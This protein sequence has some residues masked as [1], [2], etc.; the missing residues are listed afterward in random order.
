MHV[1][2]FMTI[3]ST[4]ASELTAIAALVKHDVYLAYIK[5]QA[6]E[7]QKV[8]VGKCAMFFSAVCVGALACAVVYL[9][10]N[11]NMIYNCYGVSA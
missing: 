4:S 3:N 10:V 1:Q 6:T 11:T 7:L 2:V 9:D 8:I 5:P